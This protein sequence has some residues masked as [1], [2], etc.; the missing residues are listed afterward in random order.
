[1]S[2]NASFRPLARRLLGWLFL[3]ALLGTSI[4]TVLQTM[5]VYRDETERFQLIAQTIGQVHMPQLVNNVR[6]GKSELLRRQL[7]LIADRPEVAGVLLEGLG[8]AAL[9]AGRINPAAGPDVV[10][11]VPSGDAVHGPVEL[12]FYADHAQARRHILL[13]MAQRMLE[14]GVLM[15]ASYLLIVYYL[16]REL[17][18]PL[19]LI[20]RYVGNLS[21]EREQAALDLKRPARDWYDEID[22]V[23]HGFEAMRAGLRRYVAE[24]DAAMAQL[25]AERDLLDARVERRTAALRRINGYLDIFSRTLM[26]CLHLPVAGYPDALRQVLQDL[27]EY[28]GAHSCGL[29]EEATDGQWR[30]LVIWCGEDLPACC[31]EGA[32]FR[33]AADEEGWLTDPAW[34]NMRFYRLTD[35]GSGH[36]LALRDAPV[37]ADDNEQRYQQ[38]AAEMLFSLLSRWNH[39]RQLEDTRQ[40]LERLSR[41]DPLT[42]LANRRHFDE[43]RER[44]VRRAM[45]YDLPISVLLLD[46]DRFKA[47]ND[48]YGHGAG[49]ECLVRIARCLAQRFQRAG[50][51]PARL[52]GEEFAVLLPGSGH[53]EARLAAERLRQA[54]FDLAI[55]HADSPLGRVTVSVG[56]ASWRCADYT[57]RNFG[58]LMEEADRALY[59]AKSFGRNRVGGATG[60]PVSAMADLSPVD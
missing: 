60:E 34:P 25:A 3:L 53:D 29:A 56:F 51:L 55:E 14:L 37:P 19:R 16:R 33:L 20:A 28:I 41:S 7:R 42:G 31:S 38:M 26:R 22:M 46:V 6:A 10:V 21:P 17:G 13:A 44:E 58:Q 9:S 54:I 30:W 48:R 50:D 43:H 4:A 8:G 12:R 40:E 1:M 27:A 57:D 47:Y 23:L 45:R 39:A 32:C 36:L 11:R 52:G 49:D 2:D 15:A 59:S 5:Q 18:R 35:G 24:R